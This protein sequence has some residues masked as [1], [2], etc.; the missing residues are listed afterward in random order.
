MAVQLIVHERK[1]E[2]VNRSYSVNFLFPFRLQCHITLIGFPLRWLD[3]FY[4]L[5]GFYLSYF[6]RCD[7]KN[8]ATLIPV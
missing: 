6:I 4:P 2:R 5:V 3:F 8:R 1:R 7:S